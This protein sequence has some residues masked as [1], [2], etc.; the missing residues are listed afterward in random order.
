MWGLTVESFPPASLFFNLLFLKSSSLLLA[1]N[2]QRC[3][4]T[5][6]PS[7]RWTFQLQTYLFNARPGNKNAAFQLLADCWLNGVLWKCL[8]SLFIRSSSFLRSFLFLFFSF[9]VFW[10]YFQK[11]VCVQT[12]K[13]VFE[14]PR[15]N[16]IN[17]FTFFLIK[18]LTRTLF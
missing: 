6:I 15:Q 4:N 14:P 13:D 5:S 7:L 2:S 9:G 10:P 18:Y 1:L 17:L 8:L 12:F 11:P 3:R 16:K